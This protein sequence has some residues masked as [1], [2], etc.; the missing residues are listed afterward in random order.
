MNKGYSIKI[1]ELLER[2]IIR[3]DFEEEWMNKMTDDELSQFD[4]ESY[5]ICLD[6]GVEEK[7]PDINAACL[8]KHIDR[9]ILYK[10]MQM[11]NFQLPSGDTFIPNTG[12]SRTESP[13]SDLII[14]HNGKTKRKFGLR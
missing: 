1:A 13:Q 3:N 8:S 5:Q 11:E 12:A 10:V 7:Y 4:K 9:G 14:N 2:P 6:E